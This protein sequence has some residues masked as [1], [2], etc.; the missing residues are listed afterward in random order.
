M[1]TFT[2]D[3]LASYESLDLI[4]ELERRGIG[5][6]A[7]IIDLAPNSWTIE[8]PLR[9]RLEFLNL[10]DCVVVQLMEK[11]SDK[12]FERYGVGKFSIHPSDLP[13]IKMQL[14]ASNDEW[15]M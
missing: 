3:P 6:P 14:D 8:H 15:L 7:H 11:W 1:T 12:M 4:R 2:D 5:N 10:A 13:Q 9:D